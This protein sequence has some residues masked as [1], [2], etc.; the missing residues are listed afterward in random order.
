M[1][2]WPA[3][4]STIVTLVA[5]GGLAMA[6][7]ALADR[8]A[9]RREREARRETFRMQNFTAQREAL[10]KLQEMVEEFSRKLIDEAIRRQDD[11]QYGFSY[12][13]YD[14]A[15]NELRNVCGIF[16][17]INTLA[18]QAMN[19]HPEDEQV[20]IKR[21][22]AQLEESSRGA[23]DESGQEM[24]AIANITIRLNHLLKEYGEF[25]TEMLIQVYRAGSYLVLVEALNYLRAVDKCC[26]GVLVSKYVH[27]LVIDQ[28]EARAQLQIAIGK[29]LNEGPFAEMA[30]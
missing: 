10:I 5:G 24:E 26:R 29:A 2:H 3:T 7:Q 1:T 27:R 19:A 13:L 22:L 25:R 20:R 11:G 23:L 9:R 16:Q 6:G 17:R 30:A 15:E 8:R 21:E 28:Q 4:L 14:N 12:A 18:D